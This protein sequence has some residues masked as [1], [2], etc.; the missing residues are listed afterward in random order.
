MI[1]RIGLRLYLSVLLFRAHESA[2]FV[3]RHDA[4]SAG[5]GRL[6]VR[7]PSVSTC[8]DFNRRRVLM[9]LAED[10]LKEEAQRLLERAQELRASIPESKEK[11]ASSESTTEIIKDSPW[12]VSGQD[13]VP[14]VGYR[15][16]IDIG[17]E[18]GT[19][20]DPRWGASG[21]RIEFTLDVKFLTGEASIADDTV[22]DTMVK[23]NFGG[24][25]S[26]VCILQ[27]AEMARLRG[28]FERM[29]CYGGGY[30]IDSGK[31]QTA[32]FFIN[33][34]GTP[35]SGSSSEMFPYQKELC[36]FLFLVLAIFQIFQQRK[37]LSPFDKLD[38]TLVG[39]VKR[40]VS[41]ESFAQ[42]QSKPQE[43]EMPSNGSKKPKLYS[44]P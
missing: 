4:A 15:F 32:R 19:W 31:T 34:E 30:R 42:C 44:I 28:G 25:S 41:L 29:K 14:G 36:I 38:G 40:A 17:R 35:E 24:K 9:R 33:V 20:M 12:S 18:E 23:D 5:N 6:Q 22:R 27:S 8:D 13:D 2:G 39:D 26:P 37:E 21:K 10:E 7:D 1:M 3:V 16:Y 43:K 11:V